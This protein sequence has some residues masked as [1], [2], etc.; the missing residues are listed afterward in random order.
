MVSKP[1]YLVAVGEEGLD[2]AQGLPTQLAEQQVLGRQPATHPMSDPPR[3]MHT[4]GLGVRDYS[5]DTA[6]RGH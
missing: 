4:L 1:W 3:E 2:G 5:H 6:L